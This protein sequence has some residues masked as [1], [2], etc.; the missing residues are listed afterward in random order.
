M[1]DLMNIGG[2]I[3]ATSEAGL[4]RVKAIESKLM[5][6]DQVEFETHHVLHAGTYARTVNVKAGV[7]FTNV[8]IKIPTTL[9]VCGHVIVTVDDCGAM[10]VNG[11]H[12]FPVS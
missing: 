10:E 9:I 6:M 12:V 4:E 1:S 2:H 5:E 8:F 3:L 7:A 11:Y